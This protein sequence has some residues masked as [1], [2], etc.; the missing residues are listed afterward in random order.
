M[1]LLDYN[2]NTKEWSFVETSQ[3]M[4][5][6]YNDNIEPGT[7]QHEERVVVWSY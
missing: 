7:E 2:Y 4:K 3:D 6:W 5:F 1:E